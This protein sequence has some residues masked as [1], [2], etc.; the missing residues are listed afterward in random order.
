MATVNFPLIRH[1][2]FK[3]W[4]PSTDIDEIDAPEGVLTEALN[5]DF[6]NGYLENSQTA[7]VVAHPTDIA[8]DISNGYE[9]LSMKGF[10]HS[11]KGDATVYILYKYTTVH[12]VKIWL[13]GGGE[14]VPK[15]MNIDEQN[16]DIEWLEKPTEINYSLVN[17]QL[18]INLNCLVKYDDIADKEV[19][20]NLTLLYI[21]ETI[22][23]PSILT[24]ATGW[25]LTPRWLG[26]QEGCLIADSS[27]LN[28]VNENFIDGTIDDARILIKNGATIS[29]GGI[30]LRSVG[31]TIQLNAV[32]PRTIVITAATPPA[33]TGYIAVAQEL[34]IVCYDS[35]NNILQE[36][37]I[38]V[39]PDYAPL[40]LLAPSYNVIINDPRKTA[41]IEIRKA[42]MADTDIRDCKVY[43]LR[44]YLGYYSTHPYNEEYDGEFILIGLTKD[45]QRGKLSI[46]GNAKISGANSTATKL[47]IPVNNVDWRYIQ[48]ELYFKYGSIHYLCFY[49]SIDKDEKFPAT[50]SISN[51]YLIAPMKEIIILRDTLPFKYGLPADTR[52][53]NQRHIYMEVEH[54]GRIFFIKDDY[55][56]Y[57]SH[58]S[59]NM[60]IQADAFPYD[61]EVG[62]GYFIT[63]HNR[64]NRG[65]AIT[66]TNYL[67][68]FTDSGFYVYFIQ[69]SSTGS[70]KTLRLSSGSIGLSSRN[71]ITKALTGDPATD[72]L[73][74][75]DDNG[76]YFYT[77]DS[78]PPKNLILPAHEKYWREEVSPVAKANTVGFY[79]PLKREYWLKVGSDA[80]GETVSNDYT[81][82]YEL[83]YD[84]WKRQK[85]TNLGLD[86]FYGV[87]NNVLYYRSG[88][89]FVKFDISTK[90]IFVIETPY[91]TG[92]I[93]GQQ[94][95]NRM[96]P[97]IYD[98][99][100]QEVYMVFE[101]E[102]NNTT[103]VYLE[104]IVDGTNTDIGI[105]K[106]NP[107]LPF[108][109]WLTPLGIRFNRIKFRVYNTEIG[110]I[111]R[112]KEF[113]CSYTLDTKEPLGQQMVDDQPSDSYGYGR[114]YGRAYGRN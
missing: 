63:S 29:A 24:R 36:N 106:F 104:P 50:W 113:G 43:T 57:Q 41:S 19:I 88:N 67:A 114:S 80:I 98:K 30:N 15:L 73:F 52:V 75:V 85:F 84:N 65:I 62:F 101:N 58:I 27:N 93:E 53:D 32:C 39:Q 47:K 71:S 81:I 9:L 16:S 28:D 77:G 23:P 51:G 111:T 59:A 31:S 96:I 3:A 37:S 2:D 78:Q 64:I 66:P 105:F 70:F 21:E 92:H 69:P 95:Y 26:W 91:N 13:V 44:V 110:K 90:S 35:A 60:A 6:R 87:F 49:I 20:A 46:D 10:T 25:Y 83:P 103:D 108:E 107:K 100:L 56:V 102:N 94:G 54:K 33:I 86:E 1:K 89:Q 112:I 72:G 18:K 109:K 4:I 40:P 82:V 97:E 45:G 74:W 68:I 17:N 99:I 12:L 42:A 7:V 11:D 76:V 38:T 22:Y 55:K 14:T 79:N 34:I 8:T 48:Y 5:V 61:E